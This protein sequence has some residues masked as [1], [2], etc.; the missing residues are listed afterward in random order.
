[1][2]RFADDTAV[3]T[4]GDHRYGATMQRGWW[5]ER[6]PNGGYLAAVVLR[7]ITT[8]VADAARR[9]RSLTV[10]YLR[11]P[12]EGPVEIIV[13][14]ERIG[15]T[16]TVTT[17]RMTQDDALIL[18]ATAVLAIDQPGPTFAHLPLPEVPPPDALPSFPVGERH[19]T[20]R[21]RYEQRV[22]IGPLPLGD[23]PAERAV[24]GGWIRLADPEPTDT[25]VIAAFTDAWLPAIFTTLSTLVGVPTIDLTIHFRDAPP[26]AHDWCF[27]RFT[28]R[29]A[30]DGFVEEDGEIWSRD[31]RL[32]AQSR[33][34]A[35]AVLAPSR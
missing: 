21:A 28:S 1:M 6:G 18:L 8:D 26:S 25:H 4:I 20:I 14:A 22:A 34:M 11:P 35:L 27:V 23:T 12:R 17:A 7:A 24:S 3:R 2:S 30:A 29:H 15:R 5:V 10:H 9:P 19:P 31:G 13:Q 32:L 33:Q 16:T